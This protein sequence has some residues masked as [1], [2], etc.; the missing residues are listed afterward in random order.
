MDRCDVVVVGGRVGGSLAAL[1]FA[2]AGLDVVMVD[3]ASFPSATL[4]THFFRGNGLI[5]VV[6]RAGLLPDVEALGAPRLT[7]EYVYTDGDSSA[8]LSPTQEPGT[9][10]YNMSVRRLSLDVRLVDGARRSGVRVLTSTTV[11]DLMSDDGRVTGVVLDDARAIAA[12]LVV[13]ADGRRSLVARVAGAADRERH[14]GVRAI[15]YQYVEGMPGPSGAAPDGPEFSGLGDELA[16]VFPS[17]AGLSCVAISVNLDEYERVR[18]D[19][20]EGFSRLI[21][22]HRGLWDRY[23]ASRPQ[24]RVLGSGPMPDYVRQAAGEGWALVGDAGMH[25]DPWTGLGMDSAA[26]AAETLVDTYV[27][28]ADSTSWADTYE[29]R[30]DEQLL[31]SFHETVA[32]AADLSAATT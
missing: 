28:G 16:Y 4:S 11:T 13:G 30:R 6:D 1:L 26:I 23:A 24:S 5:R 20:Q 15:Y 14:P 25:Q 21:A 19:A 9:V 7:C 10:G 31:D 2:R 8:A 18:H 12:G 32:G 27:A 22:R 3:R 17:D 29:R